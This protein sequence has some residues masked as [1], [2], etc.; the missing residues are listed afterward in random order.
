MDDTGNMID[1]NKVN[2]FL[3]KAGSLGLDFSDEDNQGPK[4][5]DEFITEARKNPENAKFSDEDLTKYYNEKY[6]K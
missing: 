2:K 6:G 4:T 3:I 1:M 5:V